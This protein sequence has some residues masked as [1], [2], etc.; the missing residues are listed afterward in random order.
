MLALLMVPHLLIG[1]W[2]IRGLPNPDFDV[3]WCHM[4][5]LEALLKGINPHTLTLAYVHPDEL[6]YPA[7]YVYDGVVHIG[8]PYPPLSLFMALPGY[9]IGG[10]YRYSGLAATALSAG[11]MIYARP[12]RLS[13]LAAAL[14]LSTP[15]M[16]TVLKMGWT[17]P[18]VLLL[19]T[20]TIFCACRAPKLFPYALGLL[21]ASKQYAIFAAL[22][23][24]LL[25][26]ERGR[27]KDYAIMIGKALLV[28]TAITLPWMLWNV[29]GFLHDVI[30]LQFLL[31]FRMD[32]LSYLVWLTYNTGR[33]P[34]AVIGFIMMAPAVALM[35][36]RGA[37]TVAGFAAAVAFIFL[38]FFSFNKAAF[39][40]Y[41]FLVIGAICCAV[42][43]SGSPTDDREMQSG[44]ISHR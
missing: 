16:V 21:I 36:W 10:D 15:A 32:A 28:A 22:G 20:L 7:S 5:S 40:N 4:H 43:V 44:A 30:L 37:R 33:Q 31:P 34:P 17:E 42:A 13:F 2:S 38:S 6:K 8:F 25:P 14:F 29:R 19:F 39:I 41:Y 12:S 35:R 18:Y 24:F 3:Y 23:V 27:A 26:I 11:L 1:V 9:L